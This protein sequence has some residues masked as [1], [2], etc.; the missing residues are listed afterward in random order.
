MNKN[1]GFTLIEVLIA[2]LVLAVGLLG[3]AGLQVTSLK[4]NQS[5]YFRSQA[6]QLAYDITDRMRTN[7]LG[8]YNN[9][10]ATADDCTATLCTPSQMAGYDLKQWSD[11]LSALLPNGQGIVCKDNTPGDGAS[12]TAHNCD[13]AGNSYTIKIWWDDDRQWCCSSTICNEFSVMKNTSKNHQIGLT[14]IEIMIAL[15]IGAFLLGGLLQIFLGNKQSYRLSDGQSRLQ[16]NARYAL[17]LLS[18]DIRLSGYLGCSGVSTTNPVV[19]ANNPL[20]APNAG[21]AAVVAASIVTGGNGGNT[22]SFTTPSPALS[23]SPLNTVVKNTDA[24][25]VQFGES[26]GGFITAAMSTVDPTAAISAS[27]SCGTITL[28]TGTTASTL[29]TPLIIGNCDID[30]YF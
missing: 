22:G 18:H 12:K 30:P 15:L 28:G 27:H 23:S 13:G 11:Q 8:N 14:L 21:N 1:T 16:E 20:I 3:L 26:C 7:K 5:A 4:N 10:A 9:Q 19:I 6:T 24:I 25:T 2:M 29:G 17:E